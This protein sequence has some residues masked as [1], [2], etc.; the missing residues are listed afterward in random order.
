MQNLRHEAP[1]VVEEVE[2][3]I[4]QMLPLV[5]T[6]CHG[7]RVWYTGPHWQGA[8]IAKWGGDRNAVSKVFLARNSWKAQHGRIS[9]MVSL[10]NDEKVMEFIAVKDCGAEQCE[11]LLGPDKDAFRIFDG[12][13]LPV[14]RPSTPGM[15]QYPSRFQL[16]LDEAEFG[17]A[18]LIWQ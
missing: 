15:P 14:G 5:V 10:G 13:P 8:R 2:R 1:R 18:Q 16:F 11:L 7:G 4:R 9:L 6:D 17:R 12:V 3:K